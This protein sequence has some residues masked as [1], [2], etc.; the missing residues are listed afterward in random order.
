MTD[1]LKP[2]KAEKTESN[3]TPQKQL[4]HQQQ[5]QLLQKQTTKSAQAIHVENL[6]QNCIKDLKLD[7][8]I[9]TEQKHQQQQELEEEEEENLKTEEEQGEEEAIDLTRVE[10][11]V[12]NEENCAIHDDDDDKKEC[13]NNNNSNNIDIDDDHHHDRARSRHSRVIS[14]ESSPLSLSSSLSSSPLTPLVSPY[15]PGRAGRSSSVGSLSSSSSSSS[16][17][18]VS[19]PSANS[20][21]SSASSGGGSGGSRRKSFL[22]RFRPRTPSEM[23]QVWSAANPYIVDMLNGASGTQVDEADVDVHLHQNASASASSSAL[24]VEKSTSTTTTTT[25]SSIGVASPGNGS[26]IRVAK[27]RTIV[28]RDTS[29]YEGELGNGLSKHGKGTLNYANGDLYDGEFLDDMRNGSG[30]C[31][32]STVPILACTGHWSQDKPVEDKEAVVIYRNG[33]RYFGQIKA[34]WSDTSGSFLSKAISSHSE[35][36][37]IHFMAERGLNASNST[38]VSGTPSA[39]PHIQKHGRGE[40]HYNSGAKYYGQFVNDSLCGYG[41]MLFKGEANLEEKQYYGNWKD[42]Q[43]EGFGVIVYKDGTVY[44]GEWKNGHK[45]GKGKLTLPNG[46]R[47]E[48]V[49]SYDNIKNASYKKGV[50]KSAS[51]CSKILLRENVQEIEKRKESAKFHFCHIE[52]STL[53][54]SELMTKNKYRNF[55]ASYA[56]EVKAERKRFAGSSTNL[57]IQ[58][59][60]KRISE[61]SE[62]LS[63]ISRKSIQDAIQTYLD[64]SLYSKFVQSHYHKEEEHDDIDDVL[65]EMYN[66][67]VLFRITQDFVH[68]F[69]WRYHQSFITCQSDA[70]IQLPNALDDLY[71]FFNEFKMTVTEVLGLDGVT[72][73]GTNKLMYTIKNCITRRIYNTLFSIYKLCYEE[74]DVMYRFKFLSLCRINM[75]ELGVESQFIPDQENNR[76]FKQ[77]YNECINRLRQLSSGCFTAHDKYHQLVQTHKEVINAIDYNI[78]S[79]NMSASPTIKKQLDLGA[80]DIFP[81]YLYVFIR[82]QL[83]NVYSEYMFMFDF[84][85]EHVRSTEASYRFT[86]FENAMN[87]VQALDVNIRDEKGVLVPISQLEARLEKSIL[88]MSIQFKRERKEMPRFLWMSSLFIVIGNYV[89][90][91]THNNTQKN[92]LREASKLV[93]DG[94]HHHVEMLAK[95]F[96]YAKIILQCVGVEVSKYAGP[97]R[98]NTKLLPSTKHP[99]IDV[100]GSRESAEWTNLP[101]TLFSHRK[102]DLIVPESPSTLLPHAGS[103]L[104]L[105]N[106]VFQLTFAQMYPSYVYFSL[107]KNVEK[108]TESVSEYGTR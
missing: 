6:R 22:K 13:P 94:N 41:V 91:E 29:L 34:D 3:P 28:Y 11:E 5:Q 44:E 63:P 92:K 72:I 39:L 76:L 38:R 64:E 108:I 106:P 71:S 54:E 7:L 56:A 105:E 49:W 68:L 93:L 43:Q 59:R 36:Q 80:D 95:Y 82:A 62:P 58:H 81:V 84:M 37:L 74:Q 104:E 47:I 46:D 50:I 65:N 83:P 17:G 98:D 20:H 90:N 103:H 70:K 40:I 10:E 19:P 52:S 8:D 23:E 26:M 87:F 48:G 27:I 102:F 9:I 33:D 21:M 55:F 2:S 53:P 77:P 66:S 89:S 96:D 18:C 35:S 101:K 73:Y 1:K 99:R 78:M 85:D 51:R 12:M 86:I 61:H 79:K 16:N 25:G 69:N 100:G 97:R 88:D 32:F 75:E 14:L 4:Q 31:R 60:R 67:N 15:S 107:A 24:P 42:N 57:F 45:N 30:T